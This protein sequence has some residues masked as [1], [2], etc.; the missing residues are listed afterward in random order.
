MRIITSVA[1]ALLAVAPRAMGQTQ[2]QARI[3]FTV[4]GGYVL[5]EDLWRVDRQPVADAPLPS[6]TFAIGRRI[7]PT[8]SFG[9]SGIYFPGEHLGYVGEAYLIGLGFEDS[10]ALVYASGS[11]RN[12]QACANLDQAEK[13]ATAVALNGGLVY[14]VASRSII[15]PYVRV[16]AGL[17]FTTQSSIR[18][19]G[20]FPS[21]SNPGELADAVIYPDNGDSR[22]SPT[23]VLA[24]G[25]TS[26][27]GKGYQFRWELRD[28]IAPV[29]AVTGA[30]TL[31]GTFPPVATRIKHLISVNVGF[32]VVLER[33]RGRRY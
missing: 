18:T 27:M 5:S 2:D 15:S 8:L 10:C 1:I 24:L 7:R 11:T 30:T 26:A 21:V 23:G 6:D 33:R 20:E 22:I 28:N 3:A 17:L 32:D 16:A 13:A 25:F 19:I 9:F 31:D 29:R 4:M 14:R 12:Q